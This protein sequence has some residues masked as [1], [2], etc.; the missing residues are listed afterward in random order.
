[1][2]FYGP[3]NNDGHKMVALGIGA[4]AHRDQCS[5]ILVAQGLGLDFSIYRCSCMDT[6][7]FN[8][9]L[10]FVIAFCFAQSLVENVTSAFYSRG[11]SGLKTEN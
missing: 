1:M 11:L 3:L 2:I 6:K 5:S 8:F 10:G 7:Q 9:Y 4:S